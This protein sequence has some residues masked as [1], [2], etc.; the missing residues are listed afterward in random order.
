MR[1]L[2]RVS[3]VFVLAVG[4]ALF[5]GCSADVEQPTIPAQPTASS[6]ESQS[7]LGRRYALDESVRVGPYEIAM[8]RV[9]LITDPDE[10]TGLAVRPDIAQGMAQLDVEIKVSNPAEEGGE[11]LPQPRTAGAFRL[12]SDGVVVEGDGVGFSPPPADLSDSGSDHGLADS[13]VRRI[14]PGEAMHI[15][16]NYL[17]SADDTLLILEYRP[18]PDDEETVV[19]FQVR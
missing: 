15:Y 6:A 19:Q 11:S 9:R 17:V 10:E 3:G 18:L 4:L 16:P 7:D 8:T 13:L 12:V 5:A 14:A 1:R 2:T